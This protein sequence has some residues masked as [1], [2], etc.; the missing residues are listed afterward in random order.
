MGWSRKILIYLFIYLFFLLLALYILLE[1]KNHNLFFFLNQNAEVKQKLGASEKEKEVNVCCLEKTWHRFIDHW[2]PE[3]FANRHVLDILEILSLDM[4]QCSSNL[5]KKAFATWQHTF[6]S[7]CIA[8]Y[9]FFAWACAEI[10]ILDEKVIYAFR[11]F[12]FL[13]PFLF[14]LFLSFC[15]S[16]WPSTGLASSLT[17]SER[18]FSLWSSVVESQE[19]LLWGFSLKFA[20]FFVHISGSIEPIT[21]I[22]VSSYRRTW[23]QMIPIFVKDDDVRSETKNNARHSRLRAAW[24][25]LKHFTEKSLFLLPFQILPFSYFTARQTF[26]IFAQFVSMWF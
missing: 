18:A 24:L 11:L 12:S 23:V 5:L 14:H 8:F 2:L 6:L 1:W 17:N 19:T 15:F 10:K 26:L 4:G 9:D 25:M 3:L 22:L 13:S 7:T 16:N 21:L 20:S